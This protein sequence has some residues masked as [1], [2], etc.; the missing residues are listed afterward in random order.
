[1]VAPTLNPALR[2][3]WQAPAR[4]RVLH[5]GRGSSKSWDAAGFAVYLASNYKLK[6]LCTR[7]FQN[8]IEESV[9]SLLKGQID[10]FGLSSQFK[11]LENKIIHRRTGS[12]FLFYG[13]W[14]HIGEIKSLE[15]VDVCWIEE[16]HNLTEDQWEILEPTIR[17]E[18][19]QFWITFN[20][21][22]ATDFV[23]KRFVVNPPPSTVV[24]Q[25]NYLENPFLSQTML[26]VIAH[27]KEEDED[28]YAHVY[29][30]V[31]RADDDGVIIKRSWIQAAIDAHKVLGFKASGFKR[32]GFDVADSGNDLC[33]NVAAHGS[34]VEWADEWK[35]QEDELLKSC[36]RT[37]AAARERGASI[38]YD[39]IGVGATA[40]AK[41]KELNDGNPNPIRYEKFNA[42]AA[43]H[44]PEK[45]YQKPD[46]T[47]GDMFANIKAQTWWL[48]ADRFRNTFNAIRN[49]EKFRDDELISISSDCPKLDKLIDELS[50]P[51]R[52]YDGNGRVKV[53]SKKDLAKPNREGGAVPSPNLADA[54]VMCFSP[55][56]KAPMRI[57]DD[58]LRRA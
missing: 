29:L 53:E 20:P 28:D 13:L 10:R 44:M 8:K 9:Y 12:E 25:I 52:D 24:R 4:N 41:F 43:V 32:I 33:A 30:G 58:L 5:G 36:T 16:A 14:R 50:T 15:G 42:G 46:I 22:L 57:S 47:N 54:F 55:T 34:V 31:P 17:K 51:R 40:G 18:H 1:M 37:Y 2:D 6:F 23:Y 38:L 35:A 21:K 26:D 27:A 19:S 39:S 7:Q 45:L 3:F 48:V 56:H 11:V 49:G